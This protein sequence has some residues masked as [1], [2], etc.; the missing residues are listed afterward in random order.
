MIKTTIKTTD[1]RTI[2]QLRPENDDDVAELR[3]LA[4]DQELDDNSSFGDEFSDETDKPGAG[5]GP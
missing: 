2:T 1:G 5:D 3:R 4:Q